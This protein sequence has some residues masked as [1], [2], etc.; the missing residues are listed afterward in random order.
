MK[1]KIFLFIIPFK[2]PVLSQNTEAARK[3][4]D[5]VSGKISSFKNMKFDFT[6]V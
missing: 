3:L 5:E 4:L 6:Y 1:K 2:F